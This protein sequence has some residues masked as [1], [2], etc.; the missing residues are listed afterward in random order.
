MNE[1]H[2]LNEAELD[3]VTG[4]VTEAPAA[5]GAV[6]YKCLKCGATINASTRDTTV[7]C[8]NVT[9]RCRFQVESGKLVTQNQRP[10]AAVPVNG[11]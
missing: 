7:T 2:R 3:A 8:P 4:G 11:G 9:C 6:T 10:L 5:T 1:K